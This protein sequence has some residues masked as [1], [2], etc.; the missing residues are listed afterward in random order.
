MLLV[1]YALP[2]FLVVYA[3]D[4][5]ERE[6][7]SLLLGAL[8]WGAVA[9]TSLAGLANDGW[10]L[11]VARVGGPEFAARW[12]AALTAPIVEETLKGLGVVMIYLIARDE[13]DDVMDGFVYGAVCGLGFAVVEDVFYFI[14]VFGGRPRD[15][16]QGFFLRVVA[17]G[18]YSHVLYTGLVGMGV[19]YFVTRRE[20]V[21][22]AKR[23]GVA[24]GLSG[25][26][27]LAHFVWDSPLLD[28]FPAQPWHGI[29][30]LLVPL[31]TGVKGVPLLGFV[32]VAV[33]LARRLERR[34]LA[35]ALAPE[36]DGAAV[37][38]E[39]LEVLKDAR[40]RRV[41]RRQMERRAGRNAARLLKRLQREQVNLAM[42]R[43]KVATSEDPALAEQRAYCRSLR[44]AL[45]AVPNAA[46]AEA[47]PL[48]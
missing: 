5:Y 3:L 18:L 21:P 1:I 35:G 36:V 15:V 22:L 19:G 30:W 27:A 47:G 41:A 45:Q 26:A 13:V 34:W 8:L 11:V 2:V 12:S 40:R 29:D 14:A 25:V 10:G 4:L 48:R 42:I 31:A 9:A 39:E 37:W 43:S 33:V 23:L 38:P 16:L 24:A 7:A 44:A 46:P 6:P 20:R 32:V 28:L 17:S